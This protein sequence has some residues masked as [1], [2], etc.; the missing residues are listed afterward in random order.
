M[1]QEAE[2]I[3]SGT[4]LVVA[5]HGFGQK[6]GQ[7]GSASLSWVAN[8]ER[9][10]EQLRQ[11]HPEATHVVTLIDDHCPLRPV[12]SVLLERYCERAAAHSF[13]CVHFVT[14][15]WPWKSTAH[16]FDRQGRLL[17][18][19]AVRLRLVRHTSIATGGEME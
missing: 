8:L 7:D 5:L 16:E 3:D 17:Q 12:D 2:A 19:S 6:G 18:M 1:I 13:A 10:L 14:Y 11:R 15:E 4:T 9:G